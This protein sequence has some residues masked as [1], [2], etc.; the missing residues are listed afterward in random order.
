M[1]KLFQAAVW[2]RA[3]TDMVSAGNWSSPKPPWVVRY[4]VRIA[5]TAI[6]CTV[7]GSDSARSESGALGLPMFSVS[8]PP[9]ARTRAQTAPTISR[10]RLVMRIVLVSSRGRFAGSEV[11]LHEAGEGP[12]VGIREAVDPERERVTRETG[13]RGSVAR[14]LGGREQIAPNHADAQAA[15]AEME[16]LE[17]APREGVADVE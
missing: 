14:V 4:Q 5:P 11:D 16:R 10:I 8:Q 15:R 6:V 2:L 13:H 9:P 1:L 12:E 17:L 7:A 3:I